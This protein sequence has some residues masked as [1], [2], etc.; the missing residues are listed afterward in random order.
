MVDL[1]VKGKLLAKNINL[2]H[3]P[4]ISFLRKCLPWAGW[5]LWLLLIW[6]LRDR[7]RSRMD[8]WFPL[9]SPSNQWE[10]KV[11]AK[12]K[13]LRDIAWQDRRPLVMILGDSQVEMG[14]WYDLF[15]GVFSIRNGGLS[16]AKIQDV[17]RIAE[18][19]SSAN[20]SIVVLF[21][22]INDLGAGSSVEG[23]FRDY[24]KLLGRVS[25]SLGREQ[26][27]VVSIMPVSKGRLADGSQ[28]LN[29][30]VLNLNAA[31]QNYCA[32]EG[33]AYVDVTS[34]ISENGMLKEE[35]TWDGLHL[36]SMGYRQIA[37]RI[38]PCLLGVYEKIGR[39]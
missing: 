26:V 27:V 20:P 33:F 23:A 19:I 16:Q 38:E 36:N 17:T 1:S 10:Q 34:A 28:G 11:E 37:A 13:D 39:K 15:R 9:L 30:R 32:K 12:M 6:Q 31:L 2:T 4:V 21:C 25:S 14:N 18:I 22:G 8:V 24:G 29:A 5:L 3:C 35:L 7:L